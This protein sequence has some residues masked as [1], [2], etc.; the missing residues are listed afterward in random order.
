MLNPHLFQ[1]APVN[2]R[3]PD[4][5]ND[6]VKLNPRPGRFT[7]LA[8]QRTFI[9]L[10][11]GKDFL[12]FNN[13][14][15]S[16]LFAFHFTVHDKA[17]EMQQRRPGIAVRRKVIHLLETADSFTAPFAE[18]TVDFTVVQLQF[19]KNFL[20]FQSVFQCQKGGFVRIFTKKR[21]PARNPI[22]QMPDRD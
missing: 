12:H 17:H 14:I 3:R 9:I 20:N 22:R 16:Q 21:P 10:A 15:K 2:F 7:Q 13:F 18:N 11:L 1:Q 5:V 8:V 6:F 4:A 19:R